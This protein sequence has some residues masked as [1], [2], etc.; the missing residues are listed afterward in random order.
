M[1]CELND[2][3][4]RIWTE[5]LDSFVPQRIFDVHTHY[6]CWTFNT[7][8][9]KETGPYG[10]LFGQDFPEAGRLQLDAWD[11]A[12]MPGRQVRRLSFGFPFWPSCDFEASNRF[13]AAW[14]A[15]AA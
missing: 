6:Y 5:E 10:K 13:A 9:A 12:L 15:A 3:D 14:R 8:P 4:R 11:A 7:D 1:I 2:V